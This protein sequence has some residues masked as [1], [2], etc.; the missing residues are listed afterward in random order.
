MTTD[1]M[2]LT[3]TIE[4]EISKGWGL[5]TSKYYLYNQNRSSYFSPGLTTPPY[6]AN[7][8]FMTFTPN[9]WISYEQ[10]TSL[11]FQSFTSN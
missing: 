10:I 9:S 8:L 11:G 5:L 6:S 4:N 3:E 1:E 2:K 7:R